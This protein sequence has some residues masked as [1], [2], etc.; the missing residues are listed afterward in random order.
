MSARAVGVL[1]VVAWFLLA[2]DVSSAIAQTCRWDGTAPFCDGECGSNETEVTRLDGIPAFWVPPF[3]NVNPP[4]GSNCATGT[5]ALCCNTPGRTCRWDGT[6]PFCDGEC[7][8][9]ETQADPPPGSS[10]GSSCVTGSK[11]F[12]CHTNVVTGS[13]RSPLE[14][15]P[16]FTRYAAFWEQGSGPAWQARHGLTSAQ[17][18]HEFDTL[19]GQGYRLVEVSGYSVDD[20]DTYAAIW[21]QRQ[22]PAWQ[23]RHGL[24]SAQYQHEFDTLLGQGYRLVDVSGYTVAGQ[25]RYAAIWEQRQGP[26]WV[27]R[28][29]LTSAQYQQ[30]FDRLVGQGYRLVDVSGYTVAGEDRY[31]AIWERSQGPAWQARHGMTSA[32]YQQE[33]NTLT[34]Q[35]YR[36]ARIRGWRSGDTAHYAAIWEKIEGPAWVARHGMLSDAYQE[37][38]DKLAKEGY[39]LKHVSG[40]HTFN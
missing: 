2:M 40:Y 10:S 27:A 36:L 6:A 14:A 31:A 13:T 7:R 28:H 25:D 34:Q 4:F 37:E 16:Q 3:V 15:S 18:Q 38:F 21:E 20:K 22:G 17:Y 23:A 32:Q 30:E 11:V 29:G 26:A 33:F 12:C 19:L 35:G 39:R 1:V 8:N 24:T 9:G 5:K